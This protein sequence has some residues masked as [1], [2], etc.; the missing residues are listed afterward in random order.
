M[1][2][3]DAT[4]ISFLVIYALEGVLITIGNAFAIFVFWTQNLHHKRPC[5]ILINLAVADLLVGSTEL[6][7]IA[8][9]KITKMQA[10]L[11]KLPLNPSPR[12]THP[13]GEIQRFAMNSSVLFLALISL[14]RAYLVLWP[15]R[16][17]T[18]S[19]AA[20]ITSIAT[21]WFLGLLTAGLNAIPVF[22]TKVNSQYFVITTQVLLFIS[23][24]V[25]LI[26]YLKIRM[27]LKSTSN[28]FTPSRINRTNH[29][30]NLRLLKTI[31]LVIAVSLVFWFPTFVV[32]VT[33]DFCLQ[34]FP[35]LALWLA[36]ALHL[37]NSLLN[38]FVYTF[39]LPVYKA[40]LRK[41]WRKGRQCVEPA[42]ALS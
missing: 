15:M 25:I 36:N 5:L 22:I 24:L 38:P 31:F 8:T 10:D 21:T 1:Q 33:R 3:A 12:G 20:Y 4:T 9:S 11:R 18:S 37:A 19:E 41:L 42:V 26:S 29:D 6:L 16:H 40:A 27:R 7:L 13:L 23:L 30:R 2:M 34:C 17:R 28:Q 39:K 32:Y 14:E 35:T